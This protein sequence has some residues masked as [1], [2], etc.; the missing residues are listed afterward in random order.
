MNNETY[1]PVSYEADILQFIEAVGAPSL[2][3]RLDLA[4]NKDIGKIVLN[5]S[6]AWR[7][8]LGNY[9]MV[10]LEPGPYSAHGVAMGILLAKHVDVYNPDML[11]AYV[12][13]NEIVN[14]SCAIILS[15]AISLPASH[16]GKAMKEVFQKNHKNMVKT[17]SSRESRDKVGEEAE[18]DKDF[19]TWYKKVSK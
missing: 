12:F 8:I 1:T 3:T 6:K 10:N 17:M 15:G 5:F 14:M 2:N 19:Q 13:F 11:R 4:R 7:I 18:K 9:P 16:L